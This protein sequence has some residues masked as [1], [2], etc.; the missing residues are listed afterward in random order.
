[1]QS[2]R[3]LP[4]IEGSPDSGGH[5]TAGGGMNPAST[6]QRQGKSGRGS[7]TALPVLPRGRR[8]SP[9]VRVSWVPMTEWE[10]KAG[11]S[12]THRDP[13]SLPLH[14][15]DA[16]SPCQSDKYFCSQIKGQLSSGGTGCQMSEAGG[17][18]LQQFYREFPLPRP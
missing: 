1:M 2:A 5:S 11:H 16:R 3:D 9:R 18:S 6:Q 15:P 7:L 17:C 10:A 8:Y 14:S 12:H 13:V 4:C